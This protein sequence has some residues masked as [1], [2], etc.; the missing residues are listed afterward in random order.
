[1]HECRRDMR[2]LNRRMNVLGTSTPDALYE[3]RV[4]IS[5]TLTGWPGLDLI[6]YPRLVCI[7][8][9]DAQIAV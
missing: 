8:S 5:R 1:M 4:V 9:I 2:F 6:R 3:I 7:I